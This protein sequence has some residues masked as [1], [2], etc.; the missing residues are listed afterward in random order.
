VTSEDLGVSE[1]DT[2]EPPRSRPYEQAHDMAV[3]PRKDAG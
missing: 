3:W 1:G 2:G